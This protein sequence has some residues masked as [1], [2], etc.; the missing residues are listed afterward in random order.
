MRLSSIKHAALAILATVSLVAIG[1]YFTFAALQGDF[2]VVKR[3]QVT[4]EKQ[5]LTAE[6]DRLK[7]EVARMQ[8]LTERLSDDYLDI[9]LL[10]ERA[11]NVLGYVRA[12]EIVIR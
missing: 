8:N 5:E 3:V 4:A 7:A 11:R 1:G 6:R 9:D 10:D 2:G 12:D